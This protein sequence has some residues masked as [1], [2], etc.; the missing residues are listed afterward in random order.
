MNLAYL[1]KEQRDQIEQ[2]K[3]R[4]L[5]AY[6]LLKNETRSAI[7]SWLN[8]QPEEYREDMRRRL[9]TINDRNRKR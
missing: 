8:N 3:K 7:V 4:W 5:K 2:D 6:E 1:P 9:N